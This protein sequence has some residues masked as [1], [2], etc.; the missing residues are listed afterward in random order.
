MNFLP[1]RRRAPHPD[2]GATPIHYCAPSANATA[3]GVPR[4]AVPKARR[5]TNVFRCTCRACFRV[6]CGCG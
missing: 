5:Q 4:N 6:I 2:G 1:W 3:C